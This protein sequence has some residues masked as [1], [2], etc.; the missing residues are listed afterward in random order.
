MPRHNGQEIR[1]PIVT[2]AAEVEVIVH[3]EATPQDVFP[4]FTDPARYVQWMGSRAA[5]DPVA[6][7]AYRVP[8][9]VNARLVP[10]G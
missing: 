4:Y 2:T 1:R 9:S 5:L 8:A 6:G 3:V 7:G 10:G